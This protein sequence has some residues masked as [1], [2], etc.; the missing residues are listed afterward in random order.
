MTFYMVPLGF[1]SVPASGTEGT[2]PDLYGEVDMCVNFG[3]I[4]LAGR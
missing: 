3:L 1:G 2:T 4:D